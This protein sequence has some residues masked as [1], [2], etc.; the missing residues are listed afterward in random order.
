MCQWL[1]Y[2]AS[3]ICIQ[4]VP[5][6]FYNFVISFQ[7]KNRSTKHAALSFCC[8][9]RADLSGLAET[10]TRLYFF[11]FSVVLLFGTVEV[12]SWNVTGHREAAST[13]LLSLGLGG[14]LSIELQTLDP[15]WVPG[16]TVISCSSS[17]HFQ[18]SLLSTGSDQW[19]SANAN[20]HHHSILQAPQARHRLKRAQAFS[21]LQVKSANS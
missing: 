19:K 16:F 18:F 8:Y 4:S 1:W 14:C 12:R 9:S 15:F 3:W 20:L 21:S 10:K 7:P 2:Q 5:R 13:S 11:V 6:I 17:G